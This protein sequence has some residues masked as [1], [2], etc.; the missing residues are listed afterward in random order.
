MKARL[1]LH[2]PKHYTAWRAEALSLS[3]ARRR[4][5]P[6]AAIALATADEPCIYSSSSTCQ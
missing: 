5:N 6:L 1:F 2:S 4:L 3:K